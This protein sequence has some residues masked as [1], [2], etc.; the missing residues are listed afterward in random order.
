[1]RDDSDIISRCC[2]FFIL[3]GFFLHIERKGDVTLLL[4]L[5]GSVALLLVK[6]NEERWWPHLKNED[7]KWITHATFYK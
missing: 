7:V 4:K 1:M 5:T 3:L 2:K 6:S